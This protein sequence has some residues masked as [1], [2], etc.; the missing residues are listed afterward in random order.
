MC[1][2]LEGGNR[3]VNASVLFI[4]G[5]WMSSAVWRDQRA[6]FAPALHVISIDPRSQGRSTITTQSNTPEQRAQDLHHVVQALKLTRV[7]LVGWS[8]GVRDVA[9]YAAAFAGEGICG[10]VLVDAPAGAGAGAAISRPRELQ[11]QLERSARYELTRTSANAR[12]L[13]WPSSR[14]QARSACPG[15]R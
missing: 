13:R 2:T 15:R 10:Y 12:P 6:A 3:D 7:V 5:W 11:E 1:H 8:Q 4:P 14:A 9:A